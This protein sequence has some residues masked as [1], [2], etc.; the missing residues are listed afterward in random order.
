V[1]TGIAELVRESRSR[2]G[3]VL[4]LVFALY[5]CTFAATLKRP[6]PDLWFGGIDS[7]R[8]ALQNSPQY[9]PMAL[10]QWK[11]HA[12]FVAVA[13]PLY[14]QVGLRAVSRLPEPYRTN[15]AL[16]FP[17]ALFGALNAA[18]AYLLFRRTGFARDAALLPTALYALAPSIW[19]FGALPETYI[20]TA[21]FTNLFLFTFMGDPQARRWLRLAGLQLLACWCGP[22]QLLLALVP[23]VQV[24]IGRGPRAALGLAVRYGAV[25]LFG[26]V[27][28]FAA[29]STFR[30]ED[31]VL[32]VGYGAGGFISQELSRWAAISN[33]WDPDAWGVVLSV[34]VGL[35]QWM[36]FV[37]SEGFGALSLEVLATGL[38]GLAIS[39]SAVIAYLAWGLRTGAGG[40]FLREVP[41]LEG[42]LAGWG[43][44]VLFFVSYNPA[45]A[46]LHSG[47]I[48]L[49]LWV[50]LH[51]AHL[52]NQR[53]AAW[54]AALAVGIAAAL[55]ANG[56][57]ATRFAQVEGDAIDEAWLTTLANDGEVRAGPSDRAEP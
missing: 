13:R 38:G 57:M 19:Y 11:K 3:V 7:Y 56:V 26:F 50:V 8:V 53:R 6:I 46:F 17:C 18:L 34:A 48:L 36:P 9:H 47:P 12:L 54:R 21:F 40:A 31:G 23:G 43:G 15:L 14:G 33:L 30:I 52:P 2:L 41:G 20:V 45:E 39:L 42:M 29:L 4:V 55:L 25:L 16:V 5:Q 32:A 1:L 22:Q 27:L 51:A 44:L 35:A 10:W 37:D 49:M 24:W 28:P